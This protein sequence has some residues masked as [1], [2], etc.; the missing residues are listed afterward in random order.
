MAGRP[1]QFANPDELQRK[2]DD[3]FIYIEG[4]HHFEAD[5]DNENKDIKVYDRWPEPPSITGLCIYLG[6]E[7]RQSFHDYGKKPQFSYTIK[8][9]RLRVENAYE[10]SLIQAKN[11]TGAIFALKNLGWDD[12]QKV[13]LAGKNGGPVKTSVTIKIKRNRDED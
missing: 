4:E 1:P 5:P 11:P 9:A 3:Y 8:M 6:F 10:I 2:I 12:K 7:S 13:E